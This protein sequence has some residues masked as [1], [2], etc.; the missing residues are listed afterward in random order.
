MSE[1]LTHWRD[2]VAQ[3][4]LELG[5][6]AGEQARWRPAAGKWSAAEIV[7][8]LIGSAI[9]NYYRF[10]EAQLRADFVFTG[11]DQDAWVQVQAYQTADCPA[12]IQLWA[13]R[14]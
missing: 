3:A 1:I 8:H 14:Y 4:A 10:V 9:N 7:G 6:I 12:L 11:Y 5:R 13:A 2:V